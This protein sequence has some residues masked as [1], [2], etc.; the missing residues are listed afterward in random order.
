MQARGA[1]RLVLL[2]SIGM[3]CGLVAAEDYLP[4]TADA[5]LRRIPSYPYVAAAARRDKI[6]AGVA[7]LDRCMAS[8]EVRRLLGDPD[9]AYVAYREGSSGTVPG[10]KIWNYVLEKHAAT[11]TVPGSRVVVWFDTAGKLQAVTVHG[12]PGIE[13]SVSRRTQQCP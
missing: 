5:F 9:F 6:R 8:A 12:A 2:L 10:K 7:Q 3:M 1:I 4:P 11:E 13:S